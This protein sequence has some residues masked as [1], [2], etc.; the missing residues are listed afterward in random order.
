VGR[1]V[2]ALTV[3]ASSA[4]TLAFSLPAGGTGTVGTLS[5][6]QAEAASLAAQI[7]TLGAQVDALDQQY[8]SDLAKKAAIDQQITATEQQIAQS[9]DR[10]GKDRQVLHKAAI[11]AYLTGGTSAAASSLFSASQTAAMDSTV[12]TQVAAGDLNTSL[13]NLNT[14]LAQLGAARQTLQNQDEQ[15]AHVVAAAQSAV[16]SAQGVEAQLQSKLDQVKGNIAVLVAQQEAAQAAAAQ[17]AAEAAIAPP[18]VPSSLPAPPPAGGGAGEIAVHA[19]ETQLGVPYVW[20]GESPGHGFDCS[21]LTAWAWGQAGVYLPHYSGAQMA[22]STPVPVSDLQPGDLLFY[23][24]GGSQ[25]VAMYVGGG[26]MIEATFPGTVVRIDPVRIGTY[27]FAG[28]G[29]P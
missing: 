23:G 13:A 15:A 4:V 29:R 28:A 7:Q 10:V 18:S 24:P 16:Q 8:E 9:K 19:A 27:D 25:H 3:V 20:G 2:A 1:R 12:Y 14:A 22:D 6:A 26:E 5:S 21:G 11:E 17:A